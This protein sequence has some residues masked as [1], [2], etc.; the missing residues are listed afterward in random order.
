MCLTNTIN[1]QDAIR[2]FSNSIFPKLEITSLYLILSIRIN[3]NSLFRI[4]LYNYKEGS[5]NTGSL[6]E[7]KYNG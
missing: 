7:F 6:L 5:C 1:K 3:K 4:L 2:L